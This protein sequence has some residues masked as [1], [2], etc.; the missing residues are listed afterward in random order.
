MIAKGTT[1]NNGA[2]LAKYLTTG[3]DGER[4]ELW[5]LC[6]FAAG[7]IRDAFR[8]VH[9][10]AQAT[11]CQKPFFHVQIRC[12]DGEELTREQWRLVADRIESKLGL[13]DQPRAIAFHIDERTGH[14]HMHLAFQ[15][16]STA[17]R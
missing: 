10:L 16:G 6:G 13:T 2:K 15:P 3:K 14:E 9:V 11:H 12:P 17:R 5:E 4:A 8:S 7:D 1:H